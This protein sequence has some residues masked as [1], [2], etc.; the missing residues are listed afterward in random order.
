MPV[1]GHLIVGPAEHG[2]VV[3][4]TDL[5]AAVGGPIVTGSG[6]D[7]HSV[8]LVHLQFTDALYGRN[9]AEAAAAFVALAGQQPGPVTVTLHDLPDPDDE[10]GRYQRRS[11]AYRAVVAAVDGVA[12][13]SRHEA[14]LLARLGG[15]VARVIPLPV[16][17][18]T[19]LPAPPSAPRGRPEIGVLGF[20]HPSKGL[21]EALAEL[22]DL[23]Q[24]ID[25]TAIGRPADGHETLVSGLRAAADAAGHTWHLTGFVADAEL[26][27]R[28]RR[29]A[30]P[31]APARLI[32]ASASVNTWLANGRRPLVLE[33]P[34]TREIAQRRPGAIRLYRDG[35]LAEAVRAALADPGSTWLR[36][37]QDIGPGHDETAVAYRQFF[38]ETAARSASR[39]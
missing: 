19:E 16:A 33:G 21:A 14:R 20:V 31:L 6:H 1:T 22:R 15:G 36:P 26:P 5:A 8:D 27:T 12:V 4:A 17:R 18:G 37:G 28:L 34:Y 7:P 11:A 29:V 32:S 23:G 39:V 10:P 3:F 2:V 24:G 9:C 35:T 38:A 25:F 30:V 13:S